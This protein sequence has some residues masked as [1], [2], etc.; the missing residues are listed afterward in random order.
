MKVSYLA[1]AIVLVSS[2]TFANPRD[3]AGSKRR[4]LSPA[5]EAPALDDSSRFA[6]YCRAYS[7]SRNREDFASS[8]QNC[9]SVHEEVFAQLSEKMRSEVKAHLGSECLKN[10][11]AGKDKCLLQGLELDRKSVV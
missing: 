5:E 9:T 3:I 11:F 7:P 10:R 1:F 8:T 4:P 6:Q 2:V